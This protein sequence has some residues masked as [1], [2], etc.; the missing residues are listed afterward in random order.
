MY[1][2]NNFYK[3]YCEKVNC[4]MKKR[5]LFTL[6]MRTHVKSVV[7]PHLLMMSDPRLAHVLQQLIA[8]LQIIHS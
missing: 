7:P 6:S 1:N 3:K 4:C 2:V 8:V 5:G